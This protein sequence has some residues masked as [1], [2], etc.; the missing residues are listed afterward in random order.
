MSDKSQRRQNRAPIVWPTPQ[1]MD[2]SEQVSPLA[3]PTPH[4][5]YGET[6]PQHTGE[7]EEAQDM[8]SAEAGTKH[9]CPQCGH[10]DSTLSR[11]AGYYVRQCAKCRY[12]WATAMDNGTVVT[13]KRVQTKAGIMQVEKREPRLSPVMD[14]TPLEHEYM[15]YFRD[16]AKNYLPFDPDADHEY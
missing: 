8:A 1:E 3:P 16:P 15:G 12:Q 7:V 6:L 14:N 5:E 10:A 2:P 9:T 13:V 4:E 11:T